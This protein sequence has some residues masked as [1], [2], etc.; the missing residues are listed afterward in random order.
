[1]Q[2]KKHAATPNAHPGKLPNPLKG[3]IAKPESQLGSRRS[4]RNEYPMALVKKSSGKLTNK[5]SG[6][7]G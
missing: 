7:Y 2:M 6:A 1:M 3:Q 4:S 5:P